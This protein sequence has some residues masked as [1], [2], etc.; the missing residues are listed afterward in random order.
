MLDPAMSLF[1]A[2]CVL[3][4]AVICVCLNVLVEKTIVWAGREILDTPSCTG[5]SF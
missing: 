3:S 4:Y 1:N 5:R 2:L